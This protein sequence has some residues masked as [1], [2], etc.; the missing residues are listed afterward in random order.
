MLPILDEPYT[1]SKFL[2]F[3]KNKEDS[4]EVVLAR[5]E[6]VIEMMSKEPRQLHWPKDGVLYPE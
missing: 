6:Q 4:F 3:L 2:G 5:F 1:V